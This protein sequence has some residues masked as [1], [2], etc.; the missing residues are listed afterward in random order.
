MP[1]KHARRTVF[2]KK[3]R[4]TTWAGNQRIQAISTKSRRKLIRNKSKSA[5]EEDRFNIV[6]FEREDSMNLSIFAGYE[7]PRKPN[8]IES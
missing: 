8:G 2:V 3:V 4:N 1:R 5:R 6:E 7:K